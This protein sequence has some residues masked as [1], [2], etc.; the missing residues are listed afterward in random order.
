MGTQKKHLKSKTWG[1]KKRKWQQKRVVFVGFAWIFKPQSHSFTLVLVPEIHLSQC[2]GC[3]WC[4]AFLDVSLTKVSPDATWTS[5]VLDFGK[6]SRLKSPL[7][8]GSSSLCQR[9]KFQVVSLRETSFDQSH[10]AR[11]SRCHPNVLLKPEPRPQ[12]YPKRPP[13]L[14]TEKAW[15]EK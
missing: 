4:P 3:F 14:S 7:V 10:N 13:A 9:G 11:L 5:T 1:N 2:F 6:E 15:L 12:N 8:K